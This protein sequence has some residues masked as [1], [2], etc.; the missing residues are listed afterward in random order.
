MYS[1]FHTQTTG[2]VFLIDG[3]DPTEEAADDE[4]AEL[5]GGVSILKFDLQNRT[6]GGVSI[7]HNTFKSM[8]GPATYYQ[9]IWTAPRHF[10]LNLYAKDGKSFSTFTGFRQL[11]TPEQ[12]WFSKF[13]MPVMLVGSMLLSRWMR[14]STPSPTAPLE[15]AAA[16]AGAE[17]KKSK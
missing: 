11:D 13:G 10:V 17:S 9:F 15:A 14:P 1:E 5:E 6:H 4:E 7:A 8:N 16:G 2:E 3:A 12:S